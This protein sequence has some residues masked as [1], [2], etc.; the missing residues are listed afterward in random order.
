MYEHTHTRT[1]RALLF[2]YF[3]RFQLGFKSLGPD[4]AKPL[5]NMHFISKN[6]TKRLKKEKKPL[7]IFTGRWLEKYKFIYIKKTQ[8][9][10]YALR[11]K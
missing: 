5:Q 7:E 8:N 2:Y 10:A 3:P 9:T 4:R 6:S 1:T 11:Q